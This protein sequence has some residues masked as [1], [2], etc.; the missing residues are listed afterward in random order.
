MSGLNGKR[1][2]GGI[3]QDR[4][5][6]ERVEMRDD[7]ESTIDRIRR[8]AREMPDNRA[9]QDT[10]TIAEELEEVRSFNAELMTLL[11]EGI[12]DEHVDRKWVDRVASSLDRHGV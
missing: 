4:G 11:R 3:H 2:K 10:L 7:V 5:L 8:L 12:L 9:I 6:P 1:L